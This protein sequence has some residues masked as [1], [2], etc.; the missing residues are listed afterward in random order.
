MTASNVSPRTLDPVC[1]KPLSLNWWILER[2]STQVQ[3]GCFLVL[4]S[5]MLSIWL[6]ELKSSVS[7]FYKTVWTRARNLPRPSMRWTDWEQGFES[8][9]QVSEVCVG[10]LLP[11]LDSVSLFPLHEHM[12]HSCSGPFHLISM[13]A[14]QFRMKTPISSKGFPDTSWTSQLRPSLHPVER[15]SPTSLVYHQHETSSRS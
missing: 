3:W 7:D 11:L 5:R 4:K 1:L 12:T 9:Y 10:V 15:T 8:S 13:M 14:N 2:V 6:L